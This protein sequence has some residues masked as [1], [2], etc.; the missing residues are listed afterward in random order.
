MK[1]VIAIL[2]LFSGIHS[3]SL[4]AQDDCRSIFEEGSVLRYYDANYTSVITI[5]NGFH[6]EKNKKAHT[7]L[8][9]KIEWLSACKV[10][11]TLVKTRG[12]TNL[13]IGDYL[14]LK[15]VEVNGNKYTYRVL[16]IP[17]SKLM[18]LVKQ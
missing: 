6:Y 14:V 10:K 15:I 5:K 3:G 4:Y 2:L 13:K 11:L 16:N 12:K 1:Y 9:S 7:M 17:N 18:M 8:K